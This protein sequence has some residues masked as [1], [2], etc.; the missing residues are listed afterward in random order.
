MILFLLLG[1]SSFSWGQADSI[2]T[3]E[4]R[5]VIDQLF[6]GMRL[7]DSTLVREVFHADAQAYTTYEKNE[8]FRLHKGSVEEF[9]KAVGA[10]HEEVWDERISN[11]VIQIDDGLAQVWM[12][13]A[14]YLGDEF[15]HKGVN[16]MI[17]VHVDKR[18]QILNLADTRRRN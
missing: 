5:T 8:E 12:D 3:V 13:Y 2:R 16:S 7:G 17:L 4:V 10:S 18:W 6:E 9:I 1:A 14:F 15:S 11:V